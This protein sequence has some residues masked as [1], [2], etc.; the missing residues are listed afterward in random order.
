MA[1][2]NAETIVNDALTA[3]VTDILDDIY[4]VRPDG[5]DVRRLTDDGSSYRPVRT[6][7]GRPRRT[8]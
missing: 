4:T 3:S 1:F 5:A 6:S 7:K 2:V 8:C